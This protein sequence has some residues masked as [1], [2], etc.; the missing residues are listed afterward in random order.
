M[1]GN[2]LL[3]V[4]FEPETFGRND[5]KMRIGNSVRFPNE[6]FIGDVTE[7]NVWSNFVDLEKLKLWVGIQ[8]MLN[9]FSF[10]F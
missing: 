10:T 6:R 1:N 2:V 9:L 5:F 8:S 3:N 7:V 4:T